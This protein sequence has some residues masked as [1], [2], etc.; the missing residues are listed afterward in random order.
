MVNYVIN[1]PKSLLNLIGLLRSSSSTSL[2]SLAIDA[3]SSF[4]ADNINDWGPLL[5][6]LTSPPSSENM[7][8]LDVCNLSPE[9]AA[10]VVPHIAKL[11]SRFKKIE[12]FSLRRCPIGAKCAQFIGECLNG[13]S[14]LKRI[15]VEQCDLRSEGA[16]LFASQLFS[17]QSYSSSSESEQKAASPLELVDLGHNEI[18]VSAC[19]EIADLVKICVTQSPY[20][21][22]LQRIEFRGNNFALTKEELE[23]Q[24]LLK[25]MFSSRKSLEEMEILK[26]NIGG[27][28]SNSSSSTGQQQKHPSLPIG[29]NIK[30]M[31]SA[32]QDT[33]FVFPAL[34]YLSNQ[35]QEDLK[36]QQ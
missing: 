26:K 13:H 20:F 33:G 8:S 25:K 24:D 18:R 34:D 7:I 9:T 19:K 2:K 4:L 21:S 3:K 29:E 11:V 16:L 10:L 35:V 31:T 15:V 14:S 28:K 5:S 12:R 32:D 17:M 36:E 22:N 27:F 6:A 30:F 23:D 1:S